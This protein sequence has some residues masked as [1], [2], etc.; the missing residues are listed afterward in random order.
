MEEPDDPKI[1][2]IT[3]DSVRYGPYSME[4]L[5]DMVKQQGLFPRHDKA[6]KEGLEDWI[7]V[8]EVEGLFE[9]NT[10]AEMLEKKEAAPK[11][12]AESTLKAFEDEEELDDDEE[13]QDWEGVPRGGF[14][15]FCCLFPVI[16]FV[17]IFYGAK[18][19][20]GVVPDN[21]FPILLA[22]LAIVPLITGTFAIL[23]RFQNLV[24]SRYWFFGLF[25]PG[26]NI[27]LGY[28]LFACPP[29][30]GER[31]KLKMLGW[32][33]AVI[34][35]LIV[36]AAIGLGAMVAIKG[37]E[38]FEDV[39]EKNRAQYDDI[40]SQIKELMESREEAAE[41]EAKEKAEKGPSIVPIR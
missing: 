27:W 17:G 34:Y 35:S 28:R 6:W 23:Q 10:K 36:M 25:V 16:W 2:F 5:K 41:K 11:A 37:P 21:L 29:G 14:F 19:L 12:T 1:W 3:R 33:L 8:G 20:K 40:V 4:E 32:V 26:L 39:I 24:M 7:P 22:L 18:M 31:K 13:D 15:F 30:Y 38:I 9:K